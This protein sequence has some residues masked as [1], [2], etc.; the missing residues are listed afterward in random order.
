M[1]DLPQ[2][3]WTF[4]WQCAQDTLIHGAACSGPD[5][6]PA[7]WSF[8]NSSDCIQTYACSGPD[9]ES[10]NWEFLNPSD[11]LQAYTVA[12]LSDRRDLVM[13]VGN[14]TSNNTFLDLQGKKPFMGVSPSD[15]MC[16]ASGLGQ[17]TRDLFCS[18]GINP[19]NWKMEVK[20][21]QNSTTLLPVEVPVQYCLSETTPSRCQLKFNLPLLAIVIAFNIVKVM[22]MAVVATRMHDNPLVTLG[23]VIASFSSN[24]EPLTKDMCLVSQRYLEGLDRNNNNNIEGTAMAAP[25]IA[26][27]PQ[28]TR[29][30]T[31][32]STRHWVAINSLFCVALSAVV[33]LLVNSLLIVSAVSFSNI[34]QLGIGKASNQNIIFWDMPTQG[35]WS[36]ITSVVLANLPQL[37]FSMIYLVFNSLC[38][39]LFLALEW[40]SYAHS[41]KPLRV[42]DPH[43][44]QRST[45]FLNI[46]FRFGV[47]LMAYSSLLHW[48][49]ASVTKLLCCFSHCMGW[50]YC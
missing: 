38:T 45:Y 40:S 12:F 11:C 10:G 23:D 15:W 8:L 24:P 4:N 49:E 29:L 27:Q 9:I 19:S 47:P 42:S 26:Y 48:L 17:A 50:R 21:P 31:T 22:C 33:I 34:L 44:E 46:P 30:K 28:K 32:A 1:Q 2:N 14:Y 16:R 35:Y 37:I 39:K 13:V 18:T 3:N 7:S 25:L 41:R 36:I 5:V 20:F 43:G 6:E